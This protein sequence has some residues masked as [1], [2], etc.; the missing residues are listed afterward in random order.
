MTIKQVREVPTDLPAAHLFLDD[1]IEIASALALLPKY[2][3]HPRP[4][5]SSIRYKVGERICDTI[6][7]LRTIGGKTREFTIQADGGYVIVAKVYSSMQVFGLTDVWKEYGYVRAVFD[8]RGHGLLNRLRNNKPAAITLMTLFPVILVVALHLVRLRVP[9][10]YRYTFDLILWPVW[11]VFVYA[12]TFRHSVV[13]L[14]YF[15]EAKNECSREFR[16]LLWSAII[17]AAVG[18]L[19]TV[20]AE[21][22]VKWLLP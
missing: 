5:P 9:G 15:D 16:P 7:D 20:V 14:R 19:V 10:L 22:F 11:L 6:E 4:A 17:G 2:D 18:S 8:H 21:R 13:E 3:G 12:T 1:V